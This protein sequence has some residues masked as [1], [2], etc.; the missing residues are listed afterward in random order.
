MVASSIKDDLF[1]K[2]E[3]LKIN[4]TC[5]DESDLDYMDIISKSR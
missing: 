1:K 3:G 2:L 4:A 5:H